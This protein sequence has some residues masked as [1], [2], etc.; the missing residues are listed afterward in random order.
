MYQVAI[1]QLA[2]AT[3]VRPS[4]QG[5]SKQ[6]RQKEL[7]EYV[8]VALLRDEECEKDENGWIYV[9]I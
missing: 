1:V 9:Y 6:T 8:L 5:K 4:K 2:E 7:R 3:A